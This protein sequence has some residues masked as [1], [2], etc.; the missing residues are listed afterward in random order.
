[1][2]RPDLSTYGGRLL[3]EGYAGQ[4]LDLNTHSIFNYRNE[5]AAGIDFGLFVVRGA[6]ADTCKLPGAAGDKVVGVS[7]RHSVG[8][9]DISGN[10]LYLQNAMVPALEIGRIRVVCENGC[11]PDDPVFVRYAGT[12]VL[13]AA[14]S[15]TVANETFAFANAVWVSTTAAGGLGVIRILK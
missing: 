7:V 12:G 3:D 8:V 10:V 4:V 6:A 13:G 5:G 1:M 14:R 9:A 11:N 2:S 15:A